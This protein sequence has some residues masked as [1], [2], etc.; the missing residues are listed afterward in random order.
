MYVATIDNEEKTPTYRILSPDLQLETMKIEFF[1]NMAVITTVDGK[2]NMRYG[3]E[4]SGE[5]KGHINLDKR[6]GIKMAD[7]DTSPH[8]VKKIGELK[9]LFKN[10][11]DEVSI[12]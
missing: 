8:F 6:K 4:L 2:F 9:K 7:L 1:S 3:S 11:P 10:K 12:Q 5:N